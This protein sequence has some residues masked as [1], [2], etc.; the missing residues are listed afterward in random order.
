[1]PPPCDITIKLA[2]YCGANKYRN[3]WQERL[4][5]YLLKGLGIK[6]RGDAVEVSLQQTTMA[7]KVV[8][9]QTTSQLSVFT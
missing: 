9:T 8:S 7:A 6:R 1:M 4:A 5:R 2:N 3:Y